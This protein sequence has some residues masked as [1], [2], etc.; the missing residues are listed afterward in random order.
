MG[1]V[2]IG[3]TV[4][5]LA[6]V[7]GPVLIQLSTHDVNSGNAQSDVEPVVAS[8]LSQGCLQL[9]A[10]M[11]GNSAMMSLVHGRDVDWASSLALLPSRF[12]VWLSLTARP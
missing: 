7:S 12:K 9:L 8:G 1:P 4:T 3:T 10:R 11:K 6:A 2:D 5:A